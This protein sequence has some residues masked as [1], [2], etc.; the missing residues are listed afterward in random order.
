MF[1]VDG[2][3]H[4][5]KIPVDTRKEA[6]DAL[7]KLRQGYYAR[8]RTNPNRKRD[9]FYGPGYSGMNVQQ[10]QRYYVYVSTPGDK[11]F[12]VRTVGFT[13]SAWKKL[14]T[15]GKTKRGDPIYSYVARSK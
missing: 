13:E 12:L 5:D 6:R 9:V 4:W 2:D 11:R 14:G 7:R 15:I 3:W 8:I 1:V 10:G